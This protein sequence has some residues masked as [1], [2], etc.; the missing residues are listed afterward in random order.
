MKR[1]F[2]AT[3]VG[4]LAVGGC[5]IVVVPRPTATDAVVN[6][7]DRSITETRHG[8]SLSVRV[9]ELEVASFRLDANVTS[10]YIAITNRSPEAVTVPL[11]TFTLLD[12]QGNQYHPLDSGTLQQLVASEP[13]LLIPY[14]YV[15]YYYLQDSEKA[16]SLNAFDS[17]LPFYAA[18]HPGELL[19]EALPVEAILPG[20]RV[21]GMIYFKIDLAARKSVDLRVYLPSSNPSG[22]PDFSF[23]FAI[24]K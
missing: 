16:G 22:T 2:L 7:A 24:E 23:P 9:Q 3:C 4:L 1:W 15:G 5:G 20:A 18:N 19:S 10:F 13:S 14:P 11:A 21:A 6:P 8:L 12:D 17:S